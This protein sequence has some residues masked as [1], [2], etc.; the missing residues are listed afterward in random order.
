MQLNVNYDSDGTVEFEILRKS[1]LEK[2][3]TNFQTK[4]FNIQYNEFFSIKDLGYFDIIE[5]LQKIG[6]VY[7]TRPNSYIIDREDSFISINVVTREDKKI[8]NCIIY[9]DSGAN[10]KKV[11]KE[12]PQ[13]FT[14]VKTNRCN[15]NIR[16]YYMQ[17]NNRL[18][19][20]TI[21]ETINEVV[22]P[23]AYP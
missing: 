6:N 13:H 14:I 23:Q 10:I 2:L 22:V 5:G 17:S 18:D 9:S 3:V 7:C 11:I 21:P 19:Y 16:W 15:I 4:N 12:I 1:I 8:L 20:T